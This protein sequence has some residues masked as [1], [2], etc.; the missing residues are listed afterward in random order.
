VAILLPCPKCGKRVNLQNEYAGKKWKC[1]GCKLKFRVPDPKQHKLGSVK[2]SCGSL[3]ETWDVFAKEGVFCP[4]CQKIYTSGKASK[5]PSI[6]PVDKRKKGK[7]KK[8]KKQA[9]SS[10]APEVLEIPELEVDDE[11]LLLDVEEEVIDGAELLI[12]NDLELA[13][14]IELGEEIELVEDIELIEDTEL[15][16]D[17][18]EKLPF[19]DRRRGARRKGDR[20][21]GDRRKG[22]R[23]KPE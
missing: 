10:P 9:P 6:I 22:G 3:I 18:Q 12:E 2:C 7:K 17:E 8:E 16:S 14:E 20:R 15:V 23:R 1:T 5:L 11:D 21:K 19:P 13:E 4:A